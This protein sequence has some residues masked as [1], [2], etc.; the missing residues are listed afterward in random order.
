MG[1]NFFSFSSIPAHFSLYSKILP[2]ICKPEV[3]N[4][5]IFPKFLLI[6][7]LVFLSIISENN[8]EKLIVLIPFLISLCC[9][10]YLLSFLE[11]LF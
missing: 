8:I 3:S 4:D 9:R 2:L 11:R 10:N 7:V 5:V 6:K 1:A